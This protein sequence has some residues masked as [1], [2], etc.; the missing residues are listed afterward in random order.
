MLVGVLAVDE[1]LLSAMLINGTVGIELL[2]MEIFS[3][4]LVAA[5][6]LGNV[7]ALETEPASELTTVVGALSI[8]LVSSDALG[9]TLFAG[10]EPKIELDTTPVVALVKS[11]TIGDALKLSGI[12]LAEKPVLTPENV[13]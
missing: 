6:V 8:V 2:I 9:R 7:L 1:A 11:D 4:V 5:D 12:R 3:N 13:D 10:E